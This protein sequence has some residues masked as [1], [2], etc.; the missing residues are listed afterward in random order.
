MSATRLLL[1]L[2]ATPSLALALPNHHVPR[3][4]G[5]GNGYGRAL[6]IAGL[7]FLGPIAIGLLVR[8]VLKKFPANGIP[9]RARIDNWI[10]W[11]AVVVRRFLRGE[12]APPEELPPYS[13]RADPP[14]YSVEVER[15]H[16]V[17][18]RVRWSEDAERS[19]LGI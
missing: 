9:R 8:A 6:L 13:P 7:L 15:Y 14:P 3:S 19:E 5:D 10:Y 12:T 4:N 17:L 1:A 11:R 16:M 2:A 18:V